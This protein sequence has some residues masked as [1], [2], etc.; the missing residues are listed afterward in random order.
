MLRNLISGESR[1][2]LGPVD[3]P[4]PNFATAG[5]TGRR[6]NS[7]AQRRHL[8][9]YGGDTAIDWVMDCVDLYASTTSSAE[10]YFTKESDQD[11]QE[12]ATKPKPV[13]TAPPD[14]VNLFRRPNPYMEYTEM[15]ELAVIDLLCAG[16]FFW[17]KFRP[18]TDPNSSQFGKPLGLYRLSP[19]LV[20]IVLDKNDNPDYVEWR[21]P[22]R[23]GLP[24]KLKP[25]HVIHVKRP[26]P[27]DQWRGMSVIAGSP[28]AFDIELAVTEA[29]KNYYDHGAMPSGT[30]E[31]DRTVPPST[32]KKIKR[33]FRQLYAGKE[34]AGSVVMLER[35]LKWTP[36]GN[37]GKD[38]AYGDIASL[39]EKRISKAFK[40]PSVLLGE[41]GGADRQAVR[42]GQRIFDNK[43]MRPFLDRIQTQV[44]LQ[45]T[46]AWGVDYYID[47]EYVMPI[48]DKLD[49]ADKLGAIPGVMVKEVRNQI[50]LPT[51]ESLGIEDGKNI[52]ETVLNMPGEN[53][54]PDGQPI[55]A[56]GFA[57]KPL[58]DEAG[59]PPKGTSTRA[60]PKNKPAPAGAAVR[61][62][63]QKSDDPADVIRR[64]IAR[65]K[66]LR[67]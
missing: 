55:G 39:S 28:Q 58:A 52:D 17:L 10:Y 32:W 59:R 62:P 47:Y 48:E 19:A 26:N 13:E 57:D 34:A 21:A 23:T 18:G 50:D 65:A 25:E 43:V 38:A 1:K 51:L 35:G 27:H 49:L 24:V 42:E 7:N 60:F 30:L 11:D 53:L 44:S 31:S 67:G 63:T 46:Q 37:T 56:D 36:M 8:Q 20:E 14:L 29:M 33:Q 61:K 6:L 9:T 12:G 2:A 41:V 16:E 54:G 64:S 40:V 5:T 4:T 3:D 15:L 45:L 66:A 22:G